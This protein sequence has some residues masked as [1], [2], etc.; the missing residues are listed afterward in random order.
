MNA[1]QVYTCDAFP[2][3][4]AETQNILGITY[5]ER[6]G[7]DR[8]DKL[9]R[10]I[11]CFQ[12]AL[13]VYT[14]ASF[15]QNHLETLFSLGIAYQDTHQLASAYDAFANAIDTLESF[16]SRTFDKLDIQVEKQEFTE[17]SNKLY[18]HMA[19]VCL[20]L[21]NAIE[22]IE[23][24][25]RSK[26]RNLVELVLTRDR[27]TIFP[28]E[29]VAQLD[30]L[31]DEIASG[32]YELQNATAEDPTAL[33]QHLQ[34]LRQQRNELQDRYLPIG[35]GFQF[36]P[37][38]ATLSH[39]TAIVEFYITS[40]K[41]LVFIITNQTQKP[42]VLSPDLINQNKLAN[43]ANSYLKA[44]SNK[45]S[46]WQRRL[47]TRLHLLAKILH[48]DEIIKQIPIESDRLVLIPHRFLHCIPLHALPLAD[49]LCLLDR[50][51][52][53]VRHAPSCQLLQLVETRQRPEFSHFF[54]IQNPNNNLPYTD[55]EVETIK[56][57]FPH[58]DIL[59]KAAATKDALSNKPLSLYHCLHFSS[60]SHFNTSSP[61]LS[62]LILADAS[63]PNAPTNSDSIQYLPLGANGVIDL[64][65][66]LTVEEI[67]KLDLSQCRLVT[68]SASETA[69]TD[70]TNGSNEYIGFPGAF[71][72]A[73]SASVVG[74]LW[75]IHDLSTALLMIKFYQNLQIGLTVAVALNQ[76]QL[77][78]RDITKIELE[79]L[80]N[81][82]QLPLNP[83]VRMALRRCFYRF[84]D[85]KPFR[86][87]FHWAAFCAIGQ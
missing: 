1:L 53:G 51:P 62:A 79:Q 6:T 63:M 61:L 56:Q 71:L 64:S 67:F 48:I 33:T 4:W 40:D 34:Q 66:C 16:W 52:G 14:R 77:W 24:A 78:L 42:I 3:D 69:L 31:R 70:W 84:R 47:T 46:H 74:S 10:A 30:R 2:Q 35:S 9:E 23:Y 68:L 20:K 15:P 41:L 44:Y 39:R 58:A 29:I 36:E 59:A 54:V 21:D 26:T 11:Y 28:A 75:D 86:E 80:I 60:E 18:Q 50:F 82:N 43:W 83:T 38:R 32:Q 37:F 19:E 76:A 5:L 49:G 72:F 73:G 17:Q 55:L 85:D 7:G 22:A 57:Y 13:Q 12:N 45:K 87:P 65:K 8:A 27:H 81:A 25:E